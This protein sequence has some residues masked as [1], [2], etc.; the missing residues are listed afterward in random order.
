MNKIS[1]KKKIKISKEEKDMANIKNVQR[2]K[3][4]QT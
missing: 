2:K 4:S 1:K 3:P